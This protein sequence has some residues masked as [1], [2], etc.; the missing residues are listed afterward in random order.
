MIIP[1]APPRTRTPNL[2]IKTDYRGIYVPADADFGAGLNRV[3]RSLH[4]VVYEQ[5]RGAVRIRDLGHEPR[6]SQY[7]NLP[8][9][10]LGRGQTGVGV[11]GHPPVVDD[12]DAVTNVGAGRTVVGPRRRRNLRIGIAE[13]PRLLWFERPREV[14][15]RVDEDP[16]ARNLHDLRLTR[17][18][19]RDL[20]GPTPHPLQGLRR[21]EGG[22]DREQDDEN[23]YGSAHT[24]YSVAKSWTHSIDSYLCRT[25]SRPVDD[26]MH[27]SGRVALR[28]P[29]R[30]DRASQYS[31]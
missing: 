20:G 21:R 14:G 16:W 4:A 5:D 23:D 17:F 19:D 15:V 29:R 10:R 1:S 3:Q 13:R 8:D 11:R 30:V 12:V 31:C 9:E 22:A 26:E 25:T 27:S 18:T 24:A 7:A 2:L 28:E 6:R